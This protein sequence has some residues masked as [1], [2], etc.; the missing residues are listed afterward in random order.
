MF[1]NFRLL[2]CNNCRIKLRSHNFFLSLSPKMNRFSWSYWQRCSRYV[3]NENSESQFSHFMR[4]RIVFTTPDDNIND[5]L[6]AQTQTTA[7][8]KTQFYCFRNWW[9]RYWNVSMWM[10]MELHAHLPSSS[11]IEQLASESFRNCRALWASK[12]KMFAPFAVAIIEWLKQNQVCPHK[13]VVTAT[14]ARR[15]L[16]QK[17]S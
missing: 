17:H 13:F 10:N 6:P 2:F 15:I 4:T 12:I 14:N 7:K 16:S 9:K 5:T 3:P 1:S 11:A 8:N